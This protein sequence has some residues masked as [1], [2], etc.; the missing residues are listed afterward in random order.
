[1]LVL[2]V[3]DDPI[4]RMLH[5]SLLA[6]MQG[7]S[8]VGAS[9]VAEARSLIAQAPPQVVVLDMQ[10][11]DGSGLDVRAALD[12]QRISATLIVISAFLDTWKNRI[13]Q[14]GH[15]F[16]LGKPTAM[17][18]LQRIIEQIHHSSVP[19]GPFV[20]LDY[21][22]LACMGQHSAVIECLTASGRGEIVIEKGTLW[23]AQDDLGSGV[24]AFG[25]LALLKSCHSRVLPARKHPGPRNLEERWEHLTLDVIRISDEQARQ[26]APEQQAAA[27]PD[28]DA[29]VE[30]AMRAVVARDFPCA[31]REL[32]LASTLRP[33]DALVRHR[34]ERLRQFQ[35]QQ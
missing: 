11:P 22:Q 6:R 5:I 34:L 25:R 17:R 8:A 26:P 33:N 3:D 9:S 7:I 15:M 4:A 28:F 16:L 13:P 32:E 20:P 29:C 31:I 35:K 19:P 30:R 23:S 10:L 12:E 1:M 27:P 14:T 18:E 24:G 2:V 21:V